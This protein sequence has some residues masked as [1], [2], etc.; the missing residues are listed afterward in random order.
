V[1]KAKVEH[2]FGGTF[3]GM[4]FVGMVF[5]GCGSSSSSP[6]S[7]GTFTTSVNGSK[8][9]S[10]LTNAEK[11]QLCKDAT[12]YFQSPGVIHSE[13]KIAGFIEAQ[14][15]V[16]FD[17][18]LTDTQLQMECTQAVD[19]CANTD[20]DGGT[21]VTMCNTDQPPPASCTATV[22]DYTACISAFPQALSGAAPECSTITRASLGADAGSLGSTADPTTLPGCMTLSNKCPGIF[23][24]TSN[25]DGGAP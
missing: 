21:S 25:P 9:L 18:T 15:S 22:A 3:V 14:L 6:N 23:D 10:A 16:A 11:L 13:C 7:A 1:G 5:V 20:K 4:V 19:Q 17:G 2:R 8:P 24:S 12:A